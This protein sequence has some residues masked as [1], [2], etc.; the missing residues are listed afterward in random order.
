MLCCLQLTNLDEVSNVAWQ[1]LNSS[2]VELLDILQHPL[3]LLGDKVDGNSLSSKATAAANTVEVVLRLSGQVVVDDQGHL[4]TTVQQ[5]ASLQADWPEAK[6]P[7][8]SIAL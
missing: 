2:V 4:D 1:L 6:P 7:S 3:I 8:L 5:S